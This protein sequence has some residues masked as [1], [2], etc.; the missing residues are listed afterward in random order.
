METKLCKWLIWRPNHKDLTQIVG[1]CG[2]VTSNPIEPENLKLKWCPHCW[3]KTELV[4]VNGNCK[5]LDLFGL[6][7]AECEKHVSN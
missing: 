3:R 5:N 4:I 1:S 6:V 7:K 2:F